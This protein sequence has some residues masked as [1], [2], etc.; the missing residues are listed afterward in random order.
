MSLDLVIYIR[1]ERVLT[2]CIGLLKFAMLDV[3]IRISDWTF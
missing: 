2:Y 3:F 1:A